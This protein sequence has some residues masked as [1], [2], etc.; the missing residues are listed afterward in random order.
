MTANTEDP[1]QPRKLTAKQT[2]ADEIAQELR[3]M[4]FTGELAP[5]APLPQVQLAERWGTSTTPVREALRMLRREGLA[6]GKSHGRIVVFH[7]SLEDLRENSEIRIALETLATELAVPQIT[8]DD[9]RRLRAL[10]KEMADT[11]PLDDEGY[12]PL[13][14]AFHTTIY[15]AAHRPR[16][17]GLIDD[18]RDAASGYLRI[19]AHATPDPQRS[20][21]EHEGIYEACV[22]R[23]SRR[24]ADLMS[25]HLRHTLN[26]VATQ[27]E[28]REVVTPVSD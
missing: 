8:G 24:A 15:R 14:R 7:P 4:I 13:N 18:L 23:D 16:L 12:P 6:T 5:G 28:Q 9:L 21:E 1:P 17:L 19:F 2:L 20:Q 25:A 26:T 11:S 27:L 22:A 3:R 10:V